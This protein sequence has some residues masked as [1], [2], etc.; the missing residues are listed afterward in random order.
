[1]EHIP[2]LLHE[3]I[4]GLNIKPEGIYVDG[5]LGRAGHALEIV[6]KLSVGR[7]IAIDQ[8]EDAIHEAG[9]VLSEYKDRITFIHGNFKDIARFLD[10]AGVE[11]ADGMLFDLGVSSPQLDNA[12]R[13][14]SYMKD[15]PLDMRMDKSGSLT[16]FE[17]VNNWPEDK[18]RKIF[19]EYGEERY[20]KSIARL[21]VKKREIA[22]IET[23][24]ELANTIISM[25][26]AAA[27]GEAQHPA[28]RCFQA[29][30]IAVN[31]EL[32][33]ISSML[34]AAPSLLK[35]GGRICVISFHSL[36]DR[37]VKRSFV[38]GKKGCTCPRDIPV[39][40]CGLTP[41]L[42]LITRKPLTVS[43]DEAKLNPRARSAKLRIAERI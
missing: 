35:P 16:A 23:T 32:G 31:D 36:E 25:I 21:I 7:L 1:M 17:A 5:T 29:L 11:K 12:A 10:E 38:S 37:L 34:D 43:A 14:F 6:K 8:D 40:V 27:R 3:C 19:F 33:S 15:A 9:E 24:F 2:V 22:P 20:S 28:K 18:L 26:P 4:N 42:K 13:G 39:C 41:T 30:R